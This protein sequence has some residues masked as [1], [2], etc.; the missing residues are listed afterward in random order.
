M[1]GEK[2]VAWQLFFELWIVCRF[3]ACFSSSASKY[4]ARFTKFVLLRIKQ[5]RP[6]TGLEAEVLISKLG[7][8]A[9]AWGAIQEANLN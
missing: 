8:H 2:Y 7:G 5:A 6:L 9:S 3:R 1:N 4:E